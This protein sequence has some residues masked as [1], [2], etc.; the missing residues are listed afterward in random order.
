[1]SESHTHHIVP[2]KT[3]ATILLIL[4]GLMA[5][6]IFVAEHPTSNS[7]LNNAIALAIAIIKATLVVAYFMGVKYG[8]KLVKM[9][10]YAGFTWMLLMFVVYCDYMTRG[11]E[12]V[13]GWEKEAPGALP[14][15]VYHPPVQ[16]AE[17]MKTE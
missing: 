11:W 4:L 10:A 16:D 13:A 2:I 12:P 9:W 1:M 17:V 5:L 6:T 8:T 7:Y 3:Y 15:G 14:R